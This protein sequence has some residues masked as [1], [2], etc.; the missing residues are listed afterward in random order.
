MTR[1]SF[2]HARESGADGWFD[3]TAG[4]PR[5]EYRAPGGDAWQ[6]LAS[7]DGYP[8]TTRWPAVDAG[9]APPASR[10]RAFEARLPRGVQ[11][12]ALRITGQARAGGTVTCA[13]LEAFE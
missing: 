13:E 11:I 9:V 5:F 7:L 3:T 4:K 6:P 8:D 2:T 12:A 1:V 10:N